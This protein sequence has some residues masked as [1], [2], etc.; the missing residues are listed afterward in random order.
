MR[1][2][3]NLTTK[4]SLII[5]FRELWEEHIF[6][7]RNFIISTISELDDLEFVTNRLLQNP[8]DFANVLKLYYGPEIAN[9]FERLFREYLTI[10]ASLVNH[11]KA[12][13][14]E[15]ANED[16]ENWYKNADEIAAFLAKIN[17]YWNMKKFLSLFYQHLKMTENEAT[18][19]LTGKYAQDIIN[20]DLIQAD[21]L[22]MADIMSYGILEQFYY[23]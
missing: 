23:K 22:K 1:S 15:A 9:E 20:F 2:K 13:D 10:A 3:N 11:A 16:R 12:G 14:T 17:P 5:L 19:R 7:T 21:A 18:Y 6:W 8:T 4:I